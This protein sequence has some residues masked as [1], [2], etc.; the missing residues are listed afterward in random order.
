MRTRE[1]AY[2]SSK[3]SEKISKE[4]NSREQRVLKVGGMQGGRWCLSGKILVIYDD[5]NTQQ[6]KWKMKETICLVRGQR[7]KRFDRETSLPQQAKLRKRLKGV[8]STSVQC[9]RLGYPI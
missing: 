8:Q 6:K 9:L 7:W 3:S 2:M 5:V 4:I 1:C